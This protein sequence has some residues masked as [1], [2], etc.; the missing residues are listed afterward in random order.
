MVLG[1]CEGSSSLLED[2]ET[3]EPMPAM[4][5]KG[6]FASE[7]P[8]S[9]D[10]S[11]DRAPAW[12]YGKCFKFKSCNITLGHL[13]LFALACKLLVVTWAVYMSQ[14]EGEKLPL[15]WASAP[16]SACWPR[17]LA[18]ANLSYDPASSDDPGLW[19]W[20]TMKRWDGGR[21][22]QQQQQQQQRW[23]WR[24]WRQH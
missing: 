15:C 8:H 20:D 23:W 22:I 13:L 12:A 7:V 21:F 18:Q 14:P 16:R 1:T 6:H 24:W 11:Q 9:K 5:F 4:T 17:A 10:S 3:Q 19:N 2:Q